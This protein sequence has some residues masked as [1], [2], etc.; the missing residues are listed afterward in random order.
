MRIKIIIFY[1]GKTP[2]KYTLEYS[3]KQKVLSCL[4]FMVFI[5]LDYMIVSYP[6][7]HFSH[8][9]IYLPIH[10]HTNNEETKLWKMK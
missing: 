1:F 3:L 6:S 8:L 2:W 4:F 10:S 9:V 5:S 7:I